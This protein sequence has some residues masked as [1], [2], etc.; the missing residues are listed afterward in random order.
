[1]KDLKHIHFYEDLLEQANNE[2]VQ[3][4]KEE[5]KVACGYSCFYI[6]EVLLNV[7]KAFS[8]RL[9]APNTG[10]LDI[11]QYYMSSFICGYSRAL[12]ERAFEGGYNFLDMWCSSDT[13][14]QMNRVVEN[15]DKLS[16]I[17]NVRFTHGIIDAPLKVSPHGLK[18]YINQI[19]VEF[20][21]PLR[22]KFGCDV[23]EEALRKAVEEHN[24]MCRIFEEISELRKE[25][26]PKITPREFHI[27][28]LV[29]Y[30]CPTYLILPYLEETL[31]DLRTREKDE[32]NPW[33]GRFVVVGSEID[34]YAFSEI[35]E[36]CYAYVVADR[37]CYGA[38]PGRQQIPLNDTEPVLD[39]ICRYYLDA[40]QCPRF[41]AQEKIEERYEVAKKFAEEYNADGIIYEQAKF[42]DFWGYEK[43]LQAQKFAETTDIPVLQIDREYV[44]AG[45]GQLRTRIQAFV[46]SV[47]IKKL[48]QNGGAK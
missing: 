42:C 3:K 11:S 35:M 13:C 5:G 12:F 28:C 2:L 48:K 15:V 21:E 10:S 22:D 19:K 47:E 45:S 24:K 16:L 7:D 4:A 1:M 14:Q 34:D 38:F 18:H 8:V 44:I 33:R 27:L 17:D 31:E 30:A 23:S 39:Q 25:E 43:I 6:P 32:K 46:E 40:N 9:R 20:L 36:S 29:S 37:Y 41:M 26:N